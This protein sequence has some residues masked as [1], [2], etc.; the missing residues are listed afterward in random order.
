MFTLPQSAP[1]TKPQSI[2]NWFGLVKI[3]SNL[4]NQIEKNSSKM[5]FRL[6]CENVFGTD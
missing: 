4:L 3:A 5:L 6:V 1:K 2:K